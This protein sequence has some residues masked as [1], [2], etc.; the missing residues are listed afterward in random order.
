M[1]IYKGVQFM[2]EFVQSNLK[3]DGF[4]NELLTETIATMLD[5]DYFNFLTYAK[6][7]AQ[8]THGM[9]LTESNSYCPNR[10]AEFIEN[11][12]KDNPCVAHVY[13]PSQWI[14]HK[15]RNYSSK[16]IYRTFDQGDRYLVEYGSS[17]CAP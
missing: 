12:I 4:K 7:A 13:I 5:T 9:T 2:K 8:P 11:L 15:L 3:D 17:T 6:P 14:V 1:V 10:T 16:V